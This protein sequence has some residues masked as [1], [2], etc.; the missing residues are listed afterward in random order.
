MRTRALLRPRAALAVLIAFGSLVGVGLTASPASAHGTSRHVLSLGGS[1]HITDDESWPFSDEHCTRGLSGFDSAQ[2][3][4]DNTAVVADTNNGC[5]GEIR[6]EVHATATL[7]SSGV[8]CINGKVYLYEGT[9]ESTGDL[10]GQATFSGCLG[11]GNLRFTG[12][13][14][15][16]DEGGDYVDVDMTFT[17]AH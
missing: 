15:N 13:V 14:H 8:F 1:L 10:D 5:G 7:N 9:S 4:S 2:L 16:T 11:L 12:R 3:P 17:N 6:V